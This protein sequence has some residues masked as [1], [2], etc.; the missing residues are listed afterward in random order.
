MNTRLLKSIRLLLLDVDGVLTDGR[1]HYSDNGEELKAFSTQDGL[2]I[3]LLQKYG[4]Q[5]GL[6]S[7]RVSGAVRRRASELGI[8]LIYEGVR[9]KAALLE[10]IRGRTGITAPE[11]AFVGDDLVD[12]PVM[13]RI[14]AAIAVANAVEDV[15]SA[16]AATTR[17][18]GGR[19][20][21]REVAEA[22][23]K[24]QNRWEEVLREIQ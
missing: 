3:R 2:G 9:D 5:V 14:G 23:L 8:D 1:V 21:V 16:A 15:K 10:D 20:A 19:G 11:T 7:G 4:I 24:A 12:L 22:I 6:V 13:N 17:S 18:S